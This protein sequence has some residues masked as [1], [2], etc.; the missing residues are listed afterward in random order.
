MNNIELSKMSRDEFL[1]FYDGL[2]SEAGEKKAINSES[3]T[4][5]EQIERFAGS[6]FSAEDET[7][8]IKD[9]LSV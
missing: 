6:F 8:I 5:G 3:L 1:T 9:A 7:A 4:L 2:I